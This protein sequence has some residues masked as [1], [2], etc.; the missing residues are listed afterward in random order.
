MNKGVILGAAAAIGALLLVPGVAFAVS[1]AGR[2]VMRA[3]V[4][5]GAVAYK[6]FQRAGAEV[7]EHMEDLA[8]EFSAEVRRAQA[9]QHDGTAPGT[10]EAMPDA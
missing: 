2:P 3:A 7:Y 9:E 5:T 10:D 8:A 1:R 4:R 6:E